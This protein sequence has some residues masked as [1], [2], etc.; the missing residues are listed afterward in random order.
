MNSIGKNEPQE[1][2]SNSSPSIWRCSR[3]LQEA[4]DLSALEALFPTSLGLACLFALFAVLHVCRLPH[5]IAM[6]MAPLAGCTSLALFAFRFTLARKPL[7]PRF[8]HPA[9][10]VIFTLCL[11]N[12][13]SHFFLLNALQ[14]STNL[15]LLVLG[16]GI[17]FLSLRWLLFVIALTLIGWML[18][19]AAVGWSKE[20]GHFEV[21]LLSSIVVSLIAFAVHVRTYS[22]LEIAR[23]ELRNLSLTDTLTQLYNRRGLDT[24]GEQELHLV[25]RLNHSATLLFV[26]LD[27]MKPI[28]DTLG[29]EAG[30]A[31]LIETA[32]LL[33]EHTREADIVARIGGDEFCILMHGDL[34]A[35]QNLIDRVQSQLSQRNQEDR[36]YKLR[37]SIGA[38]AYIAD[39]HSNLSQLV[40]EADESMYQTKVAR[41][42]AL[43]Q[44]PQE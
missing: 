8:A 7:A 23:A 25:K 9:G 1:A 16:A 33:K 21:A 30:D 2:Q 19:A 22:K 5:D 40:K 31:A 36:P 13:L 10:A 4:L 20:T 17:F 35:A 6:I 15:M 39:K 42:A 26:D 32:Q 18:T 41:K 24:I 14:Q 28:N 38:V 27:D 44:E 12:V 37:L 3:E 11:T 29:H 43:R 34:I